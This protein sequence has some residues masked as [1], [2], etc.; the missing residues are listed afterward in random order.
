MFE[1]TVSVPADQW[2]HNQRRLVYLEALLLRVV[3]DQSKIQEWFS[4]ADLEG[5]RLPGLPATRDGISNKASNEKWLRQKAKQAG[6]F[7]YV[8][9]VSSLP[10]RAFDAL[11][12]RILDLPEID[13]VV[14]A[15]PDLPDIPLEVHEPDENTAPPWVLPLLRI[16]RTETYG[17][18]G[19]A[20]VILQERLP[21]GIVAPDEAE[22]ARVLVRLGLAG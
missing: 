9:H 2:A 3:R 10:A 14:M 19:E 7:H 1:L 18:I 22:A 12:S 21:P 17:D 20:W 6:R 16:M 5:Q 15:L 4:S 11:I 8:Y 13:T